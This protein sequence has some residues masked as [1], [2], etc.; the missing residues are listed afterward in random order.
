MR[1]PGGVRPLR[2]FPSGIHER[3]NQRHRNQ[4]QN[5]KEQHKYDHSRPS[6]RIKECSYTAIRN[7]LYLQYSKVK[8]VGNML[9]KMDRCSP[10]MTPSHPTEGRGLTRPRPG[11]QFREILPAARPKSP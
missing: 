10:L 11:S 5:R 3:A 1:R 2:A 7:Y 8:W 9:P 6:H 4:R